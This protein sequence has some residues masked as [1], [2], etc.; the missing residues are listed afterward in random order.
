MARDPVRYRS[1]D[2]DSGRWKEFRFRAG[3][4]VISTRSKSGTTWM[5]MICA[6][7]VLRNP[8]LPAPLAELSPWVDWLVLPKGPMFARLEAQRHRRFVKTH[9]PLDGLP[10]DDRATYIV[11][12]RHPLDMAVS[13]YHHGDNLDRARIQ[14][15]TGNASSGAGRER[16]PL[17]VWLRHWIDWDGDRHEQMDS[18]RGVMAHLSDAWARRD[19]PNIVLV[20]YDDLIGDRGGE[21]RR[22]AARLEIDVPEELWPVLVDAAGFEQMRARA[23]QLVPDGGGVIKDPAAFFRRGTSG[24]GREVLTA[25]QLERYRSRTERLARPEML[26]WLHRDIAVPDE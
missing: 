11:V 8:D 10:I 22:L 12:A 6:L 7:L 9:T 17:E 13:L 15:L 19:R 21:M 16:P 20:H 23:G 2:E 1:H 18:L 14:E 5:Q 25:A 26:S 24:G 4:I 3:D